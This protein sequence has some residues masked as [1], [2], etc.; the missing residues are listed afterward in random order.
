MK[1]VADIDA[2]SFDTEARRTDSPMRT[3]PK[4]ST[5]SR[6][7]GLFRVSN[8]NT[9]EDVYNVYTVC[10]V[11]L[12]TLSSV[13]RARTVSG[14]AAVFTAVYGVEGSALFTA[15]TLSS[16]STGHTMFSIIALLFAVEKRP[17][18]AQFLRNTS[19][20]STW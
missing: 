9:S 14:L 16:V 18:C 13:P 1:V 12:W 11:N 8:A 5:L 10:T 3:L 2:N 17:H 19:N 15:S 6:C 4:A 20:R 7:L